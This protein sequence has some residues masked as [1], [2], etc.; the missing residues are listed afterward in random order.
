[1]HLSSNWRGQDQEDWL[2]PQSHQ[3]LS[4]TYA[5]NFQLSMW[6]SR[7]Y[8]T[9]M[10]CF[11][12]S[13]PFSVWDKRIIAKHLGTPLH[14]R[15]H[16]GRQNIEW[17]REGGSR[18]HMIS[19]PL[20]Q[21]IYK[22]TSPP[23]LSMTKSMPVYTQYKAFPFIFQLRLITPSND[24]IQIFLLPNCLFIPHT[25]NISST[26][27]EIKSFSYLHILHF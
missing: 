4:I 10:T 24:S 21:E 26:F 23:V 7:T 6:S 20:R 14:L 13:L 17:W 12:H 25:K 16:T 27:W 9:M 18:E 22:I 19:L 8:I 5:P 2:L 3:I 15:L 11:A 1:M